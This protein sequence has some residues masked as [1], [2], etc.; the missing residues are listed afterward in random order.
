MNK[1]IVTRRIVHEDNELKLDYVIIEKFEKDSRVYS[2]RIDVD[3]S[4]LPTL[5]KQL[6]EKCQS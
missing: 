3:F 6:Q 2:E 1:Y 4:D 5:I